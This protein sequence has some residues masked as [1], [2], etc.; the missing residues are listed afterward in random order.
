MKQVGNLSDEGLSWI[1]RHV[2]FNFRKKYKDQIPAE[3]FNAGSYLRPFF[4]TE[5]ECLWKFESFLAITQNSP[6]K[7]LESVIDPSSERVRT[8]SIT[9]E[10]Y[11]PPNGSKFKKGEFCGIAEKAL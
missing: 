2:S 5:A 11:S 1:G 3:I 4:K 8:A 6:R 9:G 10:S 7:G